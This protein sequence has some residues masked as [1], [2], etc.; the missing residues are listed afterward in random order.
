[1]KRRVRRKED[2]SKA[3]QGSYLSVEEVLDT[4]RAAQAQWRFML[5]RWVD[6]INELFKAPEG[7][8]YLSR[9]VNLVTS[10][11]YSSDNI[12]FDVEFDEEPSS[13]FELKLAEKARKFLSDNF[14]TLGLDYQFYLAAMIGEIFGSS[15]IFLAPREKGRVKATLI[16]PWEIY[17]YYPQLELEDPSQRIVR[18][19]RMGIPEAVKL[20][21]E[22]LVKLAQPEMFAIRTLQL[23]TID[24]NVL[25][26]LET[27]VNQSYGV[28]AEPINF[29]QFYENF[30]E[31][32]KYLILGQSYSMTGEIINVYEV[33]YKELENGYVSRAVVIGN[34]VVQHGVSPYDM[35]N[36]PFSM[37]IAEPILGVNNIGVGTG[38]RVIRTQRTIKKWLDKLEEATDKMI[39]PPVVM[40]TIGGVLT[41]DDVVKQLKTPNGVVLIDSPDLKVEEY[42]PRVSLD[43]IYAFLNK[44]EQNMVENLGLSPTILGLNISGVRSASHAQLISMFASA[45]LKQKALRF[46]KFIEDIMSLWGRYLVV[47]DPRFAA[48]M[49][50]FRVEVYAHTSSPIMAMNYQELLFG[51]IETGLVDPEVLIDLL[52]IPMKSKIKREYIKKK[53]MAELIAL[54]QAA[55]EKKKK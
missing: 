10:L 50:P 27:F 13:D 32:L 15:G 54:A 35:Y 41:V 47:F 18:V 21:G 49:T 19:I 45:H 31:F 55:Q 8:D 2:V 36:Y 29:E 1:M 9:Y 48:L 46:E 30:F 38:D 17:F 43:A 39:N 52:P 7:L 3:S 12:I 33:W 37:Y 20:F 51:L 28:E 44:C 42:V 53:E 25:K 24:Q 16:Y 40:A 4:V 34:K 23:E 22:E 5:P 6:I 14:Y 26:R 11:I